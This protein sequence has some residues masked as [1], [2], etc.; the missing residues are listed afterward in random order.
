MPAS[1]HAG[2]LA[3][4]AA[5]VPLWHLLVYFVVSVVLTSVIVAILW[6][7]WLAGD[8]DPPLPGAAWGLI[9]YGLLLVFL[10]RPLRRS[11]TTLRELLTPGRDR[12]QVLWAMRC[13][14]PAIATSMGCIYLLYLPLSA[15]APDFVGW[16]L[17]EE[18]ELFWWKGPSYR[19]A[20]LI[21]LFD[22]VLLAP[23]VEE[24]LFRRL[25]L[26][27]CKAKWGVKT[28]VIGTSVAFAALHVDLLGAFV[29]SLVLSLVFL[30]TGSV[31]L[32]FVIHATNNAIAAC[33]AALDAL[34]LSGEEAASLAEF[35]AGWW[36]GAAGL[37]VGVP[38]LWWEVR[39]FLRK[40]E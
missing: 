29:F 3:S 11:G 10:R 7:E 21:E 18:A 17:L 38:W 26:P 34:L 39:A 4:P 36:W 19:L 12:P 24:L 28:A 27:V 16:W 37:G 13:A 15:I 32:P 25:L 40:T 35:Q 5:H 23:F 1:S 9:W 20:N 2:P 31:F 14:A 22:L 33:L 8:P 30:R 6:P